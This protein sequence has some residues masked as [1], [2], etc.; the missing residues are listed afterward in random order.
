MEGEHVTADHEAVITA[1]GHMIPN[2]TE[3]VVGE[4]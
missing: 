2:K 3:V 1:D 4:D